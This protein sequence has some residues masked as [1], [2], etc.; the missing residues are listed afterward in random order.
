MTAP[1]LEHVRR[2]IEDM[3]S[4]ALIRRNMGEYSLGASLHRWAM[5]LRAAVQQEERE[6]DEREASQTDRHQGAS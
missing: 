1:R 3:E 2:V 5:A 4:S 6:A